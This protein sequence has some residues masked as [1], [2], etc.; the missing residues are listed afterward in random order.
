[1]SENVNE[2]PPETGVAEIDEALSK[3]DLDADVATHP[4]QLAAALEVLQQALNRPSD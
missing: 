2:G 4:G 1:V 3:L